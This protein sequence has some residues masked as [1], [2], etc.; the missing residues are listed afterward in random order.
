MSR[1]GLLALALA[2][3]NQWVRP[4]GPCPELRDF[5]RAHAMTAMVEVLCHGNPNIDDRGEMRAGSGVIVS[6]WQVL[7]AQHLVECPTIP[8]IWVTTNQGTWRFAPEKEWVAADVARIQMASADTLEVHGPD[9]R[10]LKIT[11]PVWGPVPSYGEMVSVHT[12]LPDWG[13]RRGR[14]LSPYRDSLR[15]DVESVDGMSGG[16]TYS[17]AGLLVGIHTAGLRSHRGSEGA[18]SSPIQEGMVP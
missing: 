15:Y 16:G 13:V 1:L 14:V 2:G 4:R 7:T 8:T 5:D 18:V 12:F 11:P 10:L 17:D 9:G 3:C 6:D